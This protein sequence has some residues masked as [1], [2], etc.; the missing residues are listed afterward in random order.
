R[1]HAGLHALNHRQIRRHLQAFDLDDVV[2]LGGQ[3]ITQARRVVG[4]IKAAL[5]VGARAEQQIAQ[6]VGDLPVGRGDGFDARAVLCQRGPRR[7]CCGRRG[8]REQVERMTGGVRA[9]HEAAGAKR[10]PGVG[11]LGKLRGQKENSHRHVYP[12]GVTK[13]CKPD[14]NA[15]T[16]RYTSKTAA[17]VR[18]QVNV[19]ARASPRARSSAWSASSVS[20]ARNASAR[21]AGSSGSIWSAA[22]PATSGSE[23]RLEITGGV[24]H[25]IASTTVSPNPS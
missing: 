1:P 9:A 19:A 3:Q 2:L 8:E 5:H 20:R 18:S 6:P 14:Y 15:A 11:W 10:S 25:A 7:F 16:L 21:A 23:A 17:A 13:G 4:R 24:P 22:S 12:V